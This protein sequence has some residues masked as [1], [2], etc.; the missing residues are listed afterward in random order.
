M[1]RDYVGLESTLPL[2]IDI[3][4]LR[5]ILGPLLTAYIPLNVGIHSTPYAS[6]DGS[7]PNFTPHA[8]DGTNGSLAQF[9]AASS[10]SR[11]SALPVMISLSHSLQT[12]RRMRP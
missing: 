1:S 9:V 7:S 4:D 12:E 5:Q 10:S 2:L 8:E 11:Q 6:F 3:T